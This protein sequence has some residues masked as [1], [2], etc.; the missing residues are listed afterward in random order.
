ML[1]KS[2][3]AEPDHTR[4]DQGLSQHIRHIKLRSSTLLT[5][6][7]MLFAREVQY[8]DDHYK[9][10]PST[11]LAIL[12]TA[13]FALLTGLH[14]Y[15]L[16]RTKTWYFIA[17]WVGGM[18]EVVG[19]IFRILGCEDYPDSTQ[20]PYI[21]SQVTILIA[22]SLLAASMYMELGRIIR[23]TGGEKYSIV[24]VNW[25]TKVFVLGDVAAFLLQAGGKSLALTLTRCDVL[26]C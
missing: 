17:F 16:L 9:Y 13:V 22:P 8:E 14:G 20:M 2:I 5:M 23:L 12:T 10:P 26:I 24:R 4:G 7:T 15:Q 19:Y 11:T 25:L 18:M 21:L 6:A 3:S 1:P